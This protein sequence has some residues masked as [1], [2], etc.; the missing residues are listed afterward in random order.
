MKIFKIIIVLILFV[1]ASCKPTKY[2]DLE[3]GLYANMETNKGAILLKLEFKKTPITVA[4]FVSL[5]N[6]TNDYVSDSLKGKPYYNGIIFHRVIKEFMCQGG[7]PTGTGSG[8]PG[9]QFTDEFPKNEKGNLLLKHD[10][11]GILS[12]ANSG[13]NTN[14]SQFFITHKKTPWLDGKHTVFGNVVKGQSVVDSIAQYDTIKNV[15]IIKIGRAAKKFNAAKEFSNYQKIFEAN[16]LLTEAKV[17]KV[18]KKTLSSFSENLNK[19]TELPSGLK[20]TIIKSQ[21]GEFPQKGVNVKVNYA[22]YFTD[23]KLFDTNRKE[24]A[25]AYEVYSHVKED[26]K[27]YDPFTTVYGPDA[28]LIAGFKEG[29]QK[30]RIGDRAMLYIPSHLGYGEQGAGNIVPP[31]SDL[32]FDLELVEVEKTTN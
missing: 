11:A 16:R 22:G 28:K 1:V 17:E 24:I 31:N 14:G 19:A 13:P 20:I 25:I 26:S 10:G 15:E 18:A 30:M 12:M 32:I 8:S 7:D 27:G 9:Y 5:A 2:A 3:D 23:G 4:N 21:N 6:G 29:L